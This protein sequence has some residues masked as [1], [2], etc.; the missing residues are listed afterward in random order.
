MTLTGWNYADIIDMPDDERLRWA[1]RCE[2]YQEK[3]QEEIDR[4]KS[5]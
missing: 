1:K 2:E 3:I 5:R 4:A